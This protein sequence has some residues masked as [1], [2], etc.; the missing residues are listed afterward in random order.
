MTVISCIPQYGYPSSELRMR[1]ISDLM[2]EW[3]GEANQRSADEFNPKVNVVKSEEQYTL[4]LALPGY[5]KNEVA[6]N[7]EANMMIVKGTRNE[8]ENN[9]AHYSRREFQTGNF[10]KQ[11]G[12]P[13][14]VDASKISGKMEDG[15]LRIVL[16][17][18]EELKPKPPRTIELS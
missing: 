1:S 8:D 11:I 3:F 9:T 6:L 12:I 16:P 18:K 17:L 2:E 4:E 15:I 5:S 10:E 13:D 7:I 14:E